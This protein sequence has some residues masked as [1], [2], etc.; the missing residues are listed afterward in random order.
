[1]TTVLTR[2]D[3]E[4]FLYHE[5]DLL[6]RWEL[7]EWHALFLSDARYEIPSLDDP[8]GDPSASQ[9]FIADD[10]ELIAARITRLKSRNA[11]AENPRSMTHRLIS[12]VKVCPGPDDSSSAIAASF[13]VH[14]VR[15][16]Q[17]EVFPGWY[18][19]LIAHTA[20]GPRF[21]IRRAIVAS[22]RLRQGRLSFVL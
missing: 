7:D 11:H 15:D 4:D 3:A 14:R 21:K 19:H 12:N 9:F 22:E 20:D 16:G 8:D 6:E 18:R 10:P 1:M 2:T 13:I 5:A 17:V